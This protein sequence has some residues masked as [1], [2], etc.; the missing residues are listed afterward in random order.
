MTK[1][2]FQ[3]IKV[4]EEEFLQTVEK[5]TKKLIYKFKFGY[6]THEDIKQQA[7]IF[8]IEALEKYDKKR[9]LENFLWTHIR[10]RLFNY[11]R[12]NYKR[13]DPPCN[14]CVFNIENCANKDEDCT[15]FKCKLD[16]SMYAVWHKRN[17]SKQ[18]LMNLSSIEHASDFESKS[19]SSDE[20]EILN[21]IEEL[22][23]DPEIRSIYIK[24]KNNC[25]ISK[26]DFN[27]LVNYIKESDL[28]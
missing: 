17:N 2:I 15:E 23:V 20:I 25:K 18:K 27:K 14:G 7:Y 5:I 26:T 21:R 9:P 8:A 6:H 12:N 24:H 28:S 11:K 10:N 16:C 19:L 1:T 4:T 3:K 22:I 13:P